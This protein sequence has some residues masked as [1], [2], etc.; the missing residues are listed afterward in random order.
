M[1]RAGAKQVSFDDEPL[2]VVDDADVVLGYRSKAD[3]HAGEGILHRAFSVF[4]FNGRGEL[5]LQQRSAEKPLWPLFWSNSCCS[6]PRRGETVD[7]AARRRLVEEL[8]IE[9]EPES[10][11]TFQYHAPYEDV[12]SERERCTV[13]LVRSDDPIEV[14]PSEVAATRWVTAE[15]LD[16][17]LADEPQAY[18]PWLKLEWA[19]L[20]REFPDVL[21]R[22]TGAP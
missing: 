18:T 2:I 7:E 9:A 16:A 6:H 11:Y 21:A 13:Y 22:Y 15:A 12:G 14:H 10:V 3:V 4:V 1:S 19:R 8:G 5:L 20:R 17:A